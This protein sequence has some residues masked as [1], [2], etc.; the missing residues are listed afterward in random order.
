MKII[1]EAD[2]RAARIPV[3]TKQYLVSEGT[4]VTPLAKEY[5]AMRKIELVYGKTA[6]NSDT[7]TVRPLPKSGPKRFIDT[8]TGENLANKPEHMTHL[9]DNFLVLKTHPR[10]LLRGK[11]DSL[12]AKIIEL[13]IETKDHG[14]DA[15]FQCL[16]EALCY[17]RTVLAAEVN[18]KELQEG[19]LFGYDS[20]GLRKVS[21]NI[22]EEFGFDHPVPSADKG[23]IA[24]RLNTLR[25]QVRECELAAVAAFG[26]GRT[27]IVRAL[28]R[29]SSGIYILFCR[30][31][32]GH[33]ERGSHE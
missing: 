11:L 27:D 29:L 15:L 9:H 23:M 4:M 13:Q 21:H 2:L 17:V 5:L 8:A 18:E 30:E 20:D 1:D 12:E 33:N 14:K 7:M 16:Q 25:T 31:I 32:A 10:I 6:I 28:N 26:N 19:T 24:A 22:K 3:G